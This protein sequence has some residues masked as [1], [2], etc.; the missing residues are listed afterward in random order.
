MANVSTHLKVWRGYCASHTHMDMSS[1]FQICWHLNIHAQQFD[2]ICKLDKLGCFSSNPSLI[3]PQPLPSCWIQRQS[4][5]YVKI[6]RKPCFFTSEHR[7]CHL[8]VFLFFLTSN[9]MYFLGEFHKVSV[10][11]KALRGGNIVGPAKLRHEVEQS[12]DWHVSN[13]SIC[14]N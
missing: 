5:G 4:M 1:I 7:W 2:G 10:F 11:C 13:M 3:F 9:F 12:L 14:S 8:Y 6:Y